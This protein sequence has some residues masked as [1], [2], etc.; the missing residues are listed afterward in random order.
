[1]WIMCDLKKR[2]KII[3]IPS[4]MAAIVKGNATF[5]F[6]VILHRQRLLDLA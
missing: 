1:M 4:R 2:Q 6:E 3:E 5:L